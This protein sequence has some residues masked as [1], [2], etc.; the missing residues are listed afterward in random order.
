MEY[1]SKY[2]H[3]MLHG[4]EA[5]QEFMGVYLSTKRHEIP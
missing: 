5:M 3:A 4:E 2:L 1:I